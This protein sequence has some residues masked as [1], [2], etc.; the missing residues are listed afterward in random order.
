MTQLQPGDPVYWWRQINRSIQYPYRAR[1]VSVGP[2]SVTISAEDPNDVNARFLRNVA[3][4][5]LQSVARY[6]EKAP[7]Q[8]PAILEP[9]NSWGRFTRYSEIGE[10]LWSVRQVDEFESGRFL[11]YDRAHWV[12]GFGML[13]DARINRYLKTGLWGRSEEIEYAEFERA[14][15]AARS[16]PMWPEQIASVQRGLS[17]MDGSSPPW[18]TGKRWR[19]AQLRGRREA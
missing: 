1:V 3:A 9:A 6:C 5:R 7:E 11:S 2:K 8:G 14:W 4:E 10:D 19:P 18:L 17:I 13:G 12:D 16:S 15:K